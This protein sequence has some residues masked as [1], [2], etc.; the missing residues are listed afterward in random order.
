M[1]SA[2]AILKRKFVKYNIDVTPERMLMQ[3]IEVVEELSKTA[4]AHGVLPEDLALKSFSYVDR[5]RNLVD[6]LSPDGGYI[7]VLVTL[8][9]GQ[10]LIKIGCT[11][12]MSERIY[13][14]GIKIRF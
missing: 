1:A 7:Y 5:A 12:H 6:L 13:S 11:K 9:P 10:N 8:I 3:L 14:L 2:T 4:D